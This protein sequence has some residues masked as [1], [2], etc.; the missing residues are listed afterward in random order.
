MKR[1]QKILFD[2]NTCFLGWVSAK[3]PLRHLLRRHAGLW[4]EVDM[5]L[6]SM[7]TF[8]DW[9]NTDLRQRGNESPSKKCLFRT[10]V[11]KAC[12]WNLQKF[13]QL[14][15]STKREWIIRLLPL[16]IEQTKANQERG[17]EVEFWPK[18]R[19]QCFQLDLFVLNRCCTRFINPSNQSL[20]EVMHWLTVQVVTV[21]KLFFSLPNIFFLFPFLFLCLFLFPSF[22]LFL[23]LF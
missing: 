17:G 4:T 12:L 22:S 21:T 7:L 16:T 20:T 15:R 3:D 9:Q 13:G 23:P 6:W 14:C 18:K 19:S 10:R 1:N 5:E 11:R 8:A 2:D